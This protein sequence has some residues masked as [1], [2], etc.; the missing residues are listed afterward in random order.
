MASSY[1][2]RCDFPTTTDSV[3]DLIWDGFK[4]ALHLVVDCDPLVMSAA[5]RS[6]W[7]S[8]LAVALATVA[9]L[10]LGI[11]LALATFP[12]KRWLVAAFRA[13]MALPTVFVGVVCYAMFS[14]QGVLGPLELLYS[15]WAIVVGEFVLA[16][17]IITA[18]THGAVKAL[19]PRIGETALTLG[20]G[21][22]RRWQTYISEAR[23]GVVLAVL[24]AFGRCVTELGI[25]MMVG[26]NIKNHTRTLATATALET[27]KGEFARGIAMGVVLLVIALSVTIL[28]VLLS[29]EEKE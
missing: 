25:A 19:D 20:A 28:I 16:F 15:P 18:I 24:T 5:W 10:P 2:I 27:G 12:G 11:A 7:I 21:P 23:V 29:R 4:E 22:F 17:P 13:G 3:M 1:S 26:G 14:R 8:S 9:G 6:V